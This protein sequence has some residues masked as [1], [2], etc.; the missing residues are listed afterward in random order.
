MKLGFYND[1]VLAVIT[2]K[3]VA[4]RWSRSN[5]LNHLPSCGNHTD[6]D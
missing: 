5:F 2:D 3:Q 6:H 1:F 4:K